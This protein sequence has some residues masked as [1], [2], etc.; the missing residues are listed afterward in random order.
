MAAPNNVAPLWLP[1]YGLPGCGKSTLI[2]RI[3]K[4]AL[5]AD[6]EIF[7][8]GEDLMPGHR[9]TELLHDMTKESYLFQTEVLEQYYRQLTD[10]PPINTGVKRLVIEHVP[11]EVIHHFNFAHVNWMNTMSVH[12]RSRLQ[13]LEHRVQ[14]QRLAILSQ[15][16]VVPVS[17]VCP[18]DEAIKN[19]RKREPSVYT[20]QACHMGKKNSTFIKL[21]QFVYQLL[22]N[23]QWET[24][25]F[26][27]QAGVD[28]ADS[29]V[30]FLLKHEERNF[31]CLFDLMKSMQKKQE[32]LV[33]S[34][35]PLPPTLPTISMNDGQIPAS[36]SAEC[37]MTEG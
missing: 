23:R 34:S 37:E 12:A 27:Y 18:V 26:K 25:V 2:E 9:V 32:L 35:Q 4:H 10:L 19:L 16:C 20:Y 22:E 6:R 24:T 28:H 31:R 3:K 1:L 36:T 14:E 33:K 21:M 5:M 11:L 8:V 15:Y 7:V 17:L 30:E 13:N 29:M